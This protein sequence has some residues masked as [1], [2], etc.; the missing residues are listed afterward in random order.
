MTMFSSVLSSSEV[1]KEVLG[2]EFDRRD[3]LSGLRPRSG[4]DR[5]ILCGSESDV[6]LNAIKR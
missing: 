4:K 6:Q 5:N 3:F 1:N 2:H